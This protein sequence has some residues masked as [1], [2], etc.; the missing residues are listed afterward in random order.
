MNP[1]RV[2]S[3]TI[4]ADWATDSILGGGKPTDVTERVRLCICSLS[5][6]M[7]AS[8]SPDVCRAGAQEI[9]PVGVQDALCRGIQ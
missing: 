8:P 5:P 4:T 9:R 1:R 6:Q 7:N 3:S 2:E